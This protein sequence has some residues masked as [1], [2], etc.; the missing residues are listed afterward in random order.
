MS[1]FLLQDLL[2]ASGERVSFFYTF[3]DFTT[4]AVPRSPESYLSY[5][6]ASDRFIRARNAR[7]RRWSMEHLRRLL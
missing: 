4:P 2:D 1:F 6:E 3:E 7:I 5:V